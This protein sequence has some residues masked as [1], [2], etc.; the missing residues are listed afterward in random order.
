MSSAFTTTTSSPSSCRTCFD[1]PHKK[2][3][4]VLFSLETP[5]KRSNVEEKEE[6]ESN[7]HSAE[8][9]LE[10]MSA[11]IDYDHSSTTTTTLTQQHSTTKSLLHHKNNGVEQ[12]KIVDMKN[13][14]IELLNDDD[15]DVVSKGDL[16]SE[17]STNTTANSS[18]TIEDE[19]KIA[20]SDIITA[21]YDKIIERNSQ[22]E[23]EKVTKREKETELIKQQDKISLK[24]LWRRRHARSIDEGI[25]SEKV[26][27]LLPTSTSSSSS[28]NTKTKNNLSNL[29]KQQQ[30]KQKKQQTVSRRSK[31]NVGG[32]YSAR[33][34]AGLIVALAEEA[35]DLRVE[36]D[37]RND[38][39]LSK[40]YVNSIQVFFTRLGCAPLRF[41]AL[42]Q[43]IRDNLNADEDSDDGENEQ[44]KEQFSNKQGGSYGYV[45]ADQAFESIDL[46]N[47]GA[48][49]A[50]ELAEALSLALM[51]T[52][53]QQTQSSSSSQQTQSNK[54]QSQLQ[55][56]T[57][58][59]QQQKLEFP[60]EMLTGL[61]SRLVSLYDSNG[62]DELDR[63]EYENMV[64]DM[65]T[66]RDSYNQTN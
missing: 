23:Q 18:T 31:N 29:L 3:S 65:A 1:H 32:G 41:G 43:A 45:T 39:P 61:A 42:D 60:K 21:N 9:E 56:S 59:A 10:L 34:L 57:Q 2:T 20:E 36:V 15:D 63:E 6:D 37:A 49:D 30:K 13:P 33:T 19:K 62:D 50:D 26:L 64:R 40:K 25:R 8:L 28:S 54:L 24:R 22:D 44:E 7:S 27:R 4:S 58:Q 66:L 17:E 16:V 53:P 46:D 55:T 51:E 38:T 14:D 12:K 35:L 52:Q 48:L 5:L 47:S 11:A